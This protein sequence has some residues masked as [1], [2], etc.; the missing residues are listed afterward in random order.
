MAVEHL[1]RH[2][3][4][5][6][7]TARV[8]RGVDERVHAPVRGLVRRDD[9][10]DGVLVAD[11]TRRGLDLDPVAAQ[12]LA[13]AASL[14]SS[15]PAI[16]TAYPSS[17]S[18]RASAFPIPLDPPLTRAA[19]DAM[20]RQAIPLA[21]A[22]SVGSASLAADQVSQPPGRDAV[23]RIHFDRALERLL[24]L[25]DGADGLVG[26]AQAVHR[27]AVIRRQPKDRCVDGDRVLWLRRMGGLPRSSSTSSGNSEVRASIRADVAALRS[28]IAST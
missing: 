2:L 20:A 18:T 23:V 16:V 6:H 12:L 15:R 14:P 28:A 8:R 25:R 27:D 26:P 5:R 9:P 21:G 11:V 19:R 17:P 7:P 22:R 4:Q 3:R 13:A 24:R 10:G 1:G